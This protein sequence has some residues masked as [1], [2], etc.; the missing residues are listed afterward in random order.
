M[1]KLGT[2]ILRP[3]VTSKSRPSVWHQVDLAA[4]RG[5]GGCECETFEARMRKKLEQG[6]PPSNAFRCSHI[7]EARE[8]LADIV[9][10]RLATQ[11]PTHLPAA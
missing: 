10:S 4:Y 6:A 1:I 9:I 2:D 5:N 8:S 11:L 3:E 7:M